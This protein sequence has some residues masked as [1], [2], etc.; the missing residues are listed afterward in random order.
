MTADLCG[1]VAQ[2]TGNG[3]QL[4]L[5]DDLDIGRPTGLNEFGRQNSDRT[6]IG[7]K[8]FV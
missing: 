4:S 2:F 7:G 6:I 5:C 3:I 1:K 8:G